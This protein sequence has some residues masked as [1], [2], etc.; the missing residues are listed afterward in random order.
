M[1]IF[2]TH[3]VDSFDNELEPNGLNVHNDEET[4]SCHHR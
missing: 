3:L 2:L 4:P 1:Y